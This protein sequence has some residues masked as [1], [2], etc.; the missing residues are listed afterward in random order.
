METAVL[1]LL[2]VTLLEGQRAPCYQCEDYKGDH[3]QSSP[4]SEVRDF[5]NPRYTVLR[6]FRSRLIRRK[7]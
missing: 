6:Y 7:G 3:P 4:Y 5:T 2:L 1:L